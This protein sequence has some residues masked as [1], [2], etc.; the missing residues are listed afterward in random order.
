MTAVVAFHY[1]IHKGAAVAD[2][3]APYLAVFNKLFYQSVQS[4]F[5]G[6]L[7]DAAAF[8]DAVNGNLPI[9]TS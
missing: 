2:D 3:G 5:A 6:C 4:A 9:F 8:P 7:F 1:L